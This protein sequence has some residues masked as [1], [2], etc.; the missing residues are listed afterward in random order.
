M[1][2]H[3]HDPEHQSALEAWR[4]GKETRAIVTPFAFNVD[5]TLLGTPLAKP[6][7]RGVAM[8]IDLILVSLLTAVPSSAVALVAAIAGWV[9][10][11]RHDQV[12]HGWA[13][14][15]LRLV[16]VVV[17]FVSVAGIGEWAGQQFSDGPPKK[18]VKATD[19]V[20]LGAVTV[21]LNRCQDKA[22]VARLTPELATVLNDRF[23][24]RPESRREMAR[25]LFRNM[26]FLSDADKQAFRQQLL[27]TPK[28]DKP[29][30]C[31]VQ[32]ARCDAQLAK[33]RK[34][35]KESTTSLLD[36]GKSLINDLGLGLSWA[37]LYFTLFTALWRGRTPGKRLLK[38][39]VVRLN[40]DAITL[41][42]AFGRYGGYGAGLA[43]GLLGFLQV[44][45]DNNRQ[46]IQDK[47]GE[48]VVI[49]DRPVVRYN[50]E[51]PDSARQQEDKA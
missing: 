22:C 26:D 37:A 23:A 49:Q 39:R 40:G 31:P 51:Q 9:I 20:A 12:V 42:D 47:I 29:L 14:R 44:Y 5:E 10:A 38:L 41:A 11:G 28:D 15:W 18:A 33:A 19:V 30:S 17:I 7:R 32:L 1:S 13:R 27:A 45:W 2:E 24:D 8:A 4:E 50:G 35:P 21:A 34:L 6:F 3:P 48:T 16:V 36:W 46:C 43:T 25:E